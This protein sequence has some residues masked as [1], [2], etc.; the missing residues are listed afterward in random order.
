MLMCF[1]RSAACQPAEPG[2]PPCRRGGPTSTGFGFEATPS[3]PGAKSFEITV[4]KRGAA[5]LGLDL[6]PAKAGMALRIKAMREGLVNECNAKHP[7]VAVKEGDLITKC[8][9]KAGKPQDMLNM[10]GT[11]KELSLTIVRPLLCESAK[12]AHATIIEPEIANPHGSFE[13]TVTKRGAAKLGLDLEPAKAG[14]ALRIKAMR[15]GLVNEWNAKHPSV[16]VKEGDLITKCNGKAGKS[17]DM[18]NMIGT[19]KELSLT[20]VR[21]QYPDWWQQVPNGGLWDDSKRILPAKREQIDAVQ[22]LIDRTWKDVTTRDRS[23]GKIPK[24]KVVQ[25]QQNHN[26]RLWNRYVAARERVREQ[27]AEADQQS[28]YTLEVQREDPET[29]DCLGDEDSS[30][31]EFMLFHGTKPSACA[32]ICDKNF[33]VDLAGSGAGT[34]YGKGIYFGENSSKSDEYA[35]EEEEGIYVGL[36]AML[37][38]R[39]TCGRM[40]YTDDVKPD[41]ADICT[42]CT[43]KKRTHHS[44]LGD[45]QKARG[46]Y[47]E[48]IS[49]D[50]ALAYPEY[51]VIYRRELE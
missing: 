33:M 13:I 23:F 37:L 7:S 44:V 38:C 50:S 32:S 9:G 19:S 25:V 41:H 47:R 10:I 11:S 39:V 43:G 29:F 30:V 51:I 48:I 45:R 2:P 14:M 31:N 16:A 26:P 28:A 46:T 5:K 6:E 34:L 22:A 17:Q 49:F 12:D 18:L 36:C 21:P 3:L 20:I 24:I 1:G 40:Y 15:E 27:M 8:N 4:T 42:K 35:K